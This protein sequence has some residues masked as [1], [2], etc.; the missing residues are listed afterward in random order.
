M[1]GL[2]LL[3]SLISGIVGGNVAGAAMPE[4]KNL[5]ALGNSITGLFGGALG[6]YILQALNVIQM[7]STQVA[8]HAATTGAAATSTGLDIGSIL[9]NVGTSG[10]SGAIL[11]AIVG[12]IKN[13]MNKHS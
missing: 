13:A 6:G 8:D 2:N 3:I 5:G 4:D 12:F 1:E 7:F 10:V 9:A 11:M